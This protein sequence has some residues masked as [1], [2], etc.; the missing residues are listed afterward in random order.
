MLVGP[1]PAGA[2]R[3]PSR[4][5]LVTHQAPAPPTRRERRE[6][7]R[8]DRP[9]RDRS[10]ASARRPA[11]RPAWQSP[12]AVVSA[13]ALV[14]A[15]AI[16]V[17][18]Q[19]PT[20]SLSTGDLLTPPI[21]YAADIVDG[22]TLGRADAPVLM[23]VWSDFQC[24]FCARFVRE[25]FGTLKTQFVDTGILRIQARD[26]AI[27][28]TGDGDESLEL[29]TGAACAGKQN[30]YWAFHDLV[31]W[32]QGRENQGDHSP[33]FLAAVADRAG[34]DRAAWDACMAA[35]DVRN[36]VKA[37]TIAAR[38]AGVDATPTIALNG[39]TPIPGLPDANALIATIQELARATTGPPSPAPST[40]P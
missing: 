9:I 2:L 3:P 40:V 32:N 25:Q 39:G 18:N 10:R 19:K 26:I 29:A 38:R 17:L 1:A 24:P 23:E 36:A 16:V 27:L 12:I 22:E 13:A 5:R 33:E 11:R 30:R 8:R 21:A 15:V 20:P 31:M 28:G 34:V 37:Q 7:E 4:C 6:L 14:V 35:G